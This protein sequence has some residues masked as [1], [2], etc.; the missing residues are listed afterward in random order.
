MEARGAV[1]DLTTW[2]R[3]AGANHLIHKKPTSLVYRL[4]A[5]V[6]SNLIPPTLHLGRQIF[7][8][9]PDVVLV[10][11]GPRMGAVSYKELQITWDK[12]NFIEEGQLPKDAQV[13]AYTWKHPN[14]N[15]G[16]DRRFNNNYQIPICSYEGM[17][18]TSTSGIN[19]LLEF[20]RV[21]VTAPFANALRR[22]PKQAVPKIAQSIGTPARFRKQ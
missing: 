15:G 1:Q 7:Y 11:D 13:A 8:F 20:S 21:G 12:S 16:P 9:F 17:H 5:V 19:K 22:L 6:K 18:L 3:N 2:K 14:L 10:E 4:P